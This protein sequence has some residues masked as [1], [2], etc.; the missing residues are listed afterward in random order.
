M[1]VSLNDRHRDRSATHPTL[2][3]VGVVLILAMLSLIP[4]AVA[5]GLGRSP[6]AVFWVVV[7]TAL[8]I[9]AVAAVLPARGSR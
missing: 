7:F 2:S 1:A 3:R 8:A 5:V 9:G 4:G 6:F